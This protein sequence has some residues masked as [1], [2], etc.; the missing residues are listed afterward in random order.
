MKS[1]EEK[2]ILINDIRF[3]SGEVETDSADILKTIASEVRK[4]S[5]NS[6]LVIG[7]AISGKASLLVMVSDK[8]VKERNINAVGYY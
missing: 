8:L 5:D 2:A 4:K 7:S 6:V 1:I 3:V